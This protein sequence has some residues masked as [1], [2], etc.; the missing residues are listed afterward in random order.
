MELIAWVFMH[1]GQVPRRRPYYNPVTAT[2]L[3]HDQLL[4]LQAGEHSV[5]RQRTVCLVRPLL[6]VPLR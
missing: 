2:I 6:V 4:G 1:E 5:L 3:P